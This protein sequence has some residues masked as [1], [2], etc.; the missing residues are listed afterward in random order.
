M[1]VNKQQWTAASKK[2]TY[3]AMAVSLMLALFDRNVLLMSNL[4]GGKS[5]MAIDAQENHRALDPDIISAI[6]GA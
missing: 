6:R 3:K 1:F 2:D 5:K 4:A